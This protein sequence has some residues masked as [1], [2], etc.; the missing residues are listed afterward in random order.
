[1]PF[2]DLERHKEYQRQYQKQYRLK[3]KEHIKD[4]HN[5]NKEKIK[6][7]RADYYLKNK[8]KIQQQKKEYYNDKYSNLLKTDEGRKRQ[9][10]NKW[11]SRGVICEDWNKL[12]DWWNTTYDCMHC[13]KPLEDSDKCLD[14]DHNTGSPR[15]ILCRVC[16][17]KEY[18][19]YIISSDDDNN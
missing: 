7:Q 3:N 17:V 19:L 11:K 12:Y 2:K 10:I 14:H 9:R 16:N 13:Y 4:Y 5:K 15:A 6:A 8:E 1:M 18:H